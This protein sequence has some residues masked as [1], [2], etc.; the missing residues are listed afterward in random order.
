MSYCKPSIR[1]V[2]YGKRTKCAPPMFPVQTWPQVHAKPPILTRQ[3]MLRSMA[4][5]GNT[6][7][8]SIYR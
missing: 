4:L 5:S 8:H 2:K 3:A 1:R 6:N 7:L